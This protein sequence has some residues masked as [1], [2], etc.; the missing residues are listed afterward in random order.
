VKHTTAAAALAILLAGTARAEDAKQA[1]LGVFVETSAMKMAGMKMPEMPKLPEGVQL[2][3]G[4]KMP[5]MPGQATRKLT[6]RLWS[7]GPAPDGATAT[8][9]VPDGTK[10]G[11][12]LNLEIARPDWIKAQMEKG[13]PGTDG[14]VEIP[15]FTI[16]R[17]WGS[18]ATVRE[19]Q[20]EVIQFNGLSDE[21]KA[22]M[23]SAQQ[24][25]QQQR[26]GGGV[27]DL[28]Y[29]PD[30]TTAYWPGGRQQ[31]DVP[32]DAALPG[33]YSLVSSYTG[34]IDLPVPDSVVLLAP[35]EMSNPDLSEKVN[36]DESIHFQWKAIPGVLGYHAQI[37]GMIGKNTII[38][39]DSS[40]IKEGRE[41]NWDYM[42]M[43]EVVDLVKSKAA[44]PSDAVDVT[45]P[46][47]I[48]KGC[49]FVMF[50]MIGYGHG[51]ALGAGNPLPRLQ[52]KTTLNIMLG[53]SKMQMG[54]QGGRGGE[55]APG[56]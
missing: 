23:R 5:A 2:P 54:G 42:Q 46:I 25:A 9:T 51:A 43:S 28:Y 52:T 35:I 48:F 38:M 29:K 15:D 56:P 49:D 30:W 4:M 8:L 44:M 18:S 39:W 50:K 33:T 6:V 31:S 32:E 21:Q 45:V 11:P 41:I 14:K 37:F 16:K 3:A 22:M 36:L 24:R 55:G 17:Y 1:Y 53:G 13:A 40:E 7:P 10:I 27:G 20:P 12:K 34:N 47:A 26:G 19:G